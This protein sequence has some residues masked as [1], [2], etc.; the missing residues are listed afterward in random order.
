MDEFILE[1]NL[2]WIPYN[3]FKN[4]EYLNEGGFGII[5][6]A[7]WLNNNGDKEVILKCHNNLNENLNEFLNEWKYHASCLSSN[8]IINFY[9][10]TED[11]NT[12]KY[13]FDT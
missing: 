11:P 3:K 13:M 1:N 6:K 9:G 10:F 4:V 12:S 7:I 2:K 8:N 5:Y